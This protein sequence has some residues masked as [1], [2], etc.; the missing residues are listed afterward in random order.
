MKQVW[1]W[2]FILSA[3]IIG[4]KSESEPRSQTKPS[5]SSANVFAAMP[6]APAKPSSA[7]EVAAS[8]GITWDEPP[9]WERKAAQNAMRKATYRIPR[10][11]GDS[12]DAELAIFYFGPGQGGAIE[13]NVERWI[14]QFPEVKPDAVHRDTRT[15]RGLRQHIIRIERATFSGGM[16]GGPSE[17]KAGWGLLGAIVEAANGPYFFKV[18][19]PTRTLSAAQ[20]TF[21]QLLESVKPSA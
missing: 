11:A 6:G 2:L 7:T 10:V 12:D 18:T 1:I 9:G 15:L 8:L 3:S 20:K 13:A 17:A 5:M 4:C 21:Y 19:G 16:P 14:R